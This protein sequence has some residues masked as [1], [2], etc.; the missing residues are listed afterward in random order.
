MSKNFTS[1]ESLAYSIIKGFINEDKA[2]FYLYWKDKINTINIT[3]M[4]IVDKIFVLM[5]QEHKVG[6]VKWELKHTYNL[7]I[8]E[9]DVYYILKD[10]QCYDIEITAMAKS[11]LRYQY[12][13]TKGLEDQI[14]HIM[15]HGNTDLPYTYKIEE[16]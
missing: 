15:K 12:T 3:N 11:F 16:Q 6:G 8:D 2:K 1:Y 7:D 13:G 9:D 10:C 14:Y 4:P 5:C